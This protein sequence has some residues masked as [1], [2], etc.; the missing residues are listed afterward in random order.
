M[1]ILLL[2]GISQY[3]AMR[4]YIDQWNYYLCKAGHETY[5]VDL[6]AG[7]SMEQLKQFI[8]TQRPQVILTCNG[9][10]ADFLAEDLPRETSYCTVFY[11]NPVFHI[12]RLEKLGKESI[13]F[14]CDK[15]YAD[16][17]CEMFPEIRIVG[18]LPLSGIGSNESIVYEDRTIDLL[19]T[20]SYLDT[21]AA[22]DTIRQLPEGIYQLAMDIISYM[23][24][25]PDCLLW[26]AADQVLA[27]WKVAVSEQ[28][29][30][31]LLKV[32]SG[33]DLY[34][35]AY[36]REEIMRSIV[37]AGVP[38][39]IF[40][41][42]WEKFKCKNPQNII[43]EQGYGEVALQA[44]AN[45]KISLNI[46]PWFRGGIQ[47]RNIAAMLAGAVSL[48]DSSRYI[49]KYFC[50]GQDIA[51][52]SLKRLDLLPEQITELLADTEKAKKI[53]ESGRRKAIDGHTWEHRVNEM[54]E[55]IL[56]NVPS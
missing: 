29:R 16:F 50:N 37:D 27:D 42:G 25:E 22:F 39:H 45:T 10:C 54:L 32:F 14:S 28:E 48:T 21:N 2:K 17:I 4:S 46:M 30:W 9:I 5:I 35:R 8:E 6:V 52:Y 44:L 34:V 51:L 31:E 15:Y 49:E 11:D 3:D 19:F 33:I 23:I 53:A 47:E 55:V 7:V 1:K 36:Y 26:Q 56:M 41:N 18:F 24:A 38:I 12:D 20:G 40:G 43:R 13:V